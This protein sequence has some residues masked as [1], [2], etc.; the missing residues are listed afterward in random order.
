MLKEAKNV[1]AATATRQ[2]AGRCY[3]LI[4]PDGTSVHHDRIMTIS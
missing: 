2:E 4:D 3:F 1:A